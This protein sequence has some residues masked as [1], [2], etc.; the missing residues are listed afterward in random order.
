LAAACPRQNAKSFSDSSGVDPVQNRA[1]SVVEITLT[2]SGMALKININEEGH[3][4]LMEGTYQYQ[5]RQGEENICQT[6]CFSCCSAIFGCDDSGEKMR[7]SEEALGSQT[8][9]YALKPT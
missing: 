2:G 6:T 3:T 9:V 5:Y 8:C 4:N 7:I 1:G